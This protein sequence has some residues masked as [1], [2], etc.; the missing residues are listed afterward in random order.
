VL[1]EVK[2][3]LRAGTLRATEVKI[4][5]DQQEDESGFE[6]HGLIESV[7]TAGQTFVLRGQTISTARSGLVYENGTAANL[8]VGRRVEVDG[9]LS[10]DRLRIEATKI[11][12]E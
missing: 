10:S 12:F 8:A 9:R 1:V 5:T 6:L 3:N 4:R 7:N 11:K 2:G